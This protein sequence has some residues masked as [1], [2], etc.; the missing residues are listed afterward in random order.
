MANLS[1]TFSAGGGNNILEV[2]TG[3][4]DGRSV[5]T[6]SGTYTFGNVTNYQNMTTSY[7]DLT[8]S[9]M[10]YTP[11]AGAT[12]VSY[13]YNFMFDC[14]GYSGISHFKLLVDN[15]EVIPAYKN[16]ASNYYSSYHHG[17]FD[18]SIFYVFDLTASTDNASLGQFSS[19]STNKTLKVQGREYDGSYQSAVHYNVYTAA[20]AVA[21]YVQPILTITAYS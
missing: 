11:P 14:I 8:G 15:T 21:Q 5:T 9:T 17:N 13:E 2:L 12:K 18:T 7:V 1:D 16:V 6:P 19:W 10:A 3:V 20:V 4:A